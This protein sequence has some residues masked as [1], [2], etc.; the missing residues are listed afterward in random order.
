ME[1]R[2]GCEW[3]EVAPGAGW[4]RLDGTGPGLSRSGEVKPWLDGKEGRWGEPG[5]RV[6]IHGGGDHPGLKGEGGIKGIDGRRSLEADDLG[7]GE[8]QPRGPR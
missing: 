4:H 7:R 8:G 3:L 1:A 2:S 6:I 5:A